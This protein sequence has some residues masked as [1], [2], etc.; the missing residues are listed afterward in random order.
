M[1]KTDFD[2]LKKAVNG[3]NTEEITNEFNKLMELGIKKNHGS[4]M[5]K[6]PVKDDSKEFNVW[7]FQI[8]NG[9]LETLATDAN[10]N[11]PN[12]MDLV[13]TSIDNVITDVANSILEVAEYGWY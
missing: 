7:G 6:T 8:I 2:G 1:K 11:D 9:T 3:G 4:V 13:G 12:N 10:D 5:F